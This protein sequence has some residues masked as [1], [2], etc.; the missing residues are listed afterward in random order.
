MTVNTI[1]VSSL[2][3]FPLFSLS[4]NNLVNKKK[5]FSQIEVIAAGLGGAGAIKCSRDVVVMP[6]AALDDAAG[7]GPY[8]AIVLPGGLKGAESFGQVRPSVQVKCFFLVIN[9][10]YEVSIMYEQF[11]MTWI[12]LVYLFRCKFVVMMK[13]VH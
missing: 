2:F 8:D 6:D 4:I 11:K 1:V 13:S 5:T 12:I 3:A 10:T 9:M 7:K